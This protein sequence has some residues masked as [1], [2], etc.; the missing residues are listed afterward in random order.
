MAQ[1]SQT[2]KASKTTI[3]NKRELQKN[4]KQSKDRSQAPTSQPKESRTQLFLDQSFTHIFF[5]SLKHSFTKKKKKM[6]GME[7]TLKKNLSL[8]FNL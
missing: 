7:S 1:S 4:I 5:F 8:L 6:I 3:S 2:L